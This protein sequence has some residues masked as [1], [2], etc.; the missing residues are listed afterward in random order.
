VS[1]RIVTVPSDS[2]LTAP[3]ALFS[4]F[5]S[6][7]MPKRKKMMHMLMVDRIFQP[8]EI[9]WAAWSPGAGQMSAHRTATAKPMGRKRL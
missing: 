9:Q 1:T 3:N 2:A 5:V 7:E 8:L 6:S 4:S